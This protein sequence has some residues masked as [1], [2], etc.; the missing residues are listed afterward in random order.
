M[1]RALL[2][3]PCISR[4]PCTW[5]GVHS[6]HPRLMSVE[7]PVVGTGADDD[8]K[9]PSMCE[10]RV[11]DII[12]PPE[13]PS[14]ADGESTPAAR[15][16]KRKPR[17][18]A[19]ASS[20]PRSPRERPIQPAERQDGATA[21]R[22]FNRVP[23]NAITAPYWANTSAL[24]FSGVT[25]AC[26]AVVDRF[27]AAAVADSL[28]LLESTDVVNPDSLRCSAHALLSPLAARPRAQSPASSKPRTQ[29]RPPSVVVPS[30]TDAAESG[31][32]CAVAALAPVHQ[33]ADDEGQGDG[34]TGCVP[35]DEGLPTTL[36]SI[37]TLASFAAAESSCFAEGPPGL[38]EASPAPLLR[39]PMPG[40]LVPKRRGRPPGAQSNKAP[41]DA[42]AAQSQAIDHDRSQRPLRLLVSS[43]R[44]EPSA[45]VTQALA[46]AFGVAAHDLRLASALAGASSQPSSS[47]Y[48]CATPTPGPLRSPS[49]P[50]HTGAAALDADAFT[51]DGGAADADTAGPR[52]A[53]LDLA[54]LAGPD[55]VQSALA[56]ALRQQAVLCARNSSRLHGL[57]QVRSMFGRGGDEWPVCRFTPNVAWGQDPCTIVMRS[58]F[59]SPPSVSRARVLTA[60]VVC[61][62]RQAPPRR[63]WG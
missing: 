37:R 6:Q 2:K 40:E 39:A 50:P 24:F 23:V 51:I 32:S 9:A 11:P 21:D 47:P 29:I 33:L 43:G 61:A 14:L 52:E 8:D 48:L 16:K 7:S 26:I 58:P 13:S 4:T 45:R 56:L 25:P 62:A 57:V 63:T 3:P 18:D 44:G 35:T 49:A 59:P 30:T 38:A 36:A 34:D 53:V 10:D 12:L 41:L 28:C 5:V 55:A 42:S 19:G 27:R 1:T 31:F 15:P 20:I 17:R 54:S 46:V 22:L 60:N